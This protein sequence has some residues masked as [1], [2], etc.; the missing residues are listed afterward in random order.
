[1]TEKPTYEALEQKVNTLEKEIFDLG[2]KHKVLQEAYDEIRQ[3]MEKHAAELIEA[4]QQL[5]HE[6]K[7]RAENELALKNSQH[8]L[9]TLIDTIEGEAFI[10]DK[11]GKYLF[12]NKAFGKDFDVDPN[13]VIGKDDFFIFSPDN[14]TKLQENDKRIMA[15]RKGEY[16]E[17]TGIHGGKLLTYLTNKVPLFDDDGNVIGICGIGFD[18]TLQKK[19]EKALKDA[20]INLERTVQERT[21]QLSETVDKLRETELRYRTVADFT[22]DWEYWANLDGTLQYVSPSCER[23][24]GFSSQEFMENPSLN[25]EIVIPEDQDIWKKH[26]HDSRNESKATEIQ[27]RIRHRDGSTRWIEHTCQP[28]IGD[29]R[30]LL[31]FRAS[32]RDITHRKEVEIALQNAYSEITEMKKQLEADQTYLL[33]EIKLMHDY[34]HIIGE[35]EMFKYVMYRLEQ[36]APTDTTVLILGESGTGKELIARAIHHGSKRKDRPLIKVDCAALPENLIES[37]LFGH[38]KGAFTGAFEKRI[39]RFELANGGTIFLDEI[40]EMPLLL[41]QKLLRVLQDGS[42]E[43]LGSSKVRHTDVRVIAATNRNLEE[44]VGEERFR[45]DLWYRLNVFPLSIPPL[46]DRVDDIP[47]LVSSIISKVQ[48]R[49]GKHIKTVPANIMNNLITHPWPG[50]VRELENVIEGAVIVT[51]GDTLR[52]SA[53]L[54]APKSDHRTP[55]NIPMKSLSE[56]EK[57]HILEALNKTNWNITGKGGASELLGL[58]PSTLRG[59]MRKHGIHRPSHNL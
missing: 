38:E 26:F 41:Q 33:E 15:T 18:I 4:N 31:G 29:Q 35:S 36:I 10:K 8:L 34:E 44:D 37:E 1:M 40:G 42:F 56:M 3:E 45:K 57:E 14:A 52:L 54:K 23:I 50:N 21:A 27:F 5:K 59:R 19:M 39:G 6:I 24:S 22:Y 55:H 51:T 49:L 48:R 32:N 2:K 46:R 28:V 58:N 25:R 16:I 9:K 12:V 7:E 17:E 53:P 13:D 11:N 20:H 47:I 43:R 30:E